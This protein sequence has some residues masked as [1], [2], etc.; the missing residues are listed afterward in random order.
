MIFTP[1]DDSPPVTYA[2]SPFSASG[3]S[4]I[5]SQNGVDQVMAGGLSTFSCTYGSEMV[6]LQL[7]VQV[8]DFKALSTPQTLV[9]KVWVPNP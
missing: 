3:T 7:T 5:R 2:F 1:A 9:W 6:S 4:L 8:A